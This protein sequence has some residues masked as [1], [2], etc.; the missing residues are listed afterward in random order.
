MKKFKHI[1]NGIIWTLIVLYL[2]LIVLMHLPSVQTFLGKEVAEALADKFGTKVE[3]GKVNLGFFNRIIIDDVM[4]YDQQGDSLIYASRLSAKIDYMAATQGKISVSS[5]Q[6]FGLRANLYR[7]TAKSPANFQFVL[8][9]LASK[10]TTQHKPLDLHI[11]SLIIRRGAIAYNQRDVAPRSGVFSPQHIRVSEL[12]SHILLNHVTDNSID[13][14]LKKLSF[15]DES[16]FKLQSLHFKLQADRQK[17]TLKEF[18]LL[19]PRSELVLDDLK[20]TYRFEGKRFIPES[21]RFKGGIQ[22]SKITFADVASLVPALRHF[23]DAVFVSSRFLGTAKSISVPSLN[24]RTGSGSINLQ[25]RGSYSH[26]SSHPAWNADIANLNLSPAGVEFLVENLGSKVKIPKEIQRLGTIHLTG[27]AKGYEKVLSAKGNIETD[28]GNIS[29]QAVKS[30]DRIKASVD[31]RGVNLG[32]ILDNRKLGTVVAKIDAHGT[33]KHIFA[34]GNIARFDYGN[35]DFH[36]IDIDGDYDMKT[37]RGTASIADPNVNLSVKGDYHLGSRLYALDAAINHL[38]PTVLGMKMHDPSYSLDNISISA[39]NK[40]K[41]GH[42]DIEAPFVSLYARGQYDLTTIYGSIMRL[43]ADKLPTI[44]GISKHAAKGY[45][46]FTLQANITSAEVLQRMFGLPLSLNLPVHING[47][48]SDAEKNVNL[49]INAPNFSWDGS[50]FHD[51]N[52]ELNTIGD[53]LRMEARISQGLPYEK[54]P[55]YR[56]RA[57]AAD[58]NLSTLLYYANQSSKLPIT[59]K[60]DART[61]FFTSDNG[62]TGVHVSVNPSEIM[63]GE[64]KWLLNPADII[65]RKNELTVDMLNFSHGDQHIIINGKATPQATDSIVADLKDV[66][67]AYILNLV[68]FHSVDFAGKASG[69][70]VVKSIFQTPEAYANLDVKDFVFEN[71]PLGTLH[72]KAAYDNQEGQ[73]NIDATAEDG[74]EHLTVIN[75]YVSPKRNYIDLGIEAHNTSLKFMENFC[76]SFLN[77]VEAWCKG[78]LNVV[79]DLKNINLVGDVVAHGRM[80]MKQLGTDYTFN[81]LRAHAIPDDIQF[82]GDSIYDSHYNGKHSHFALIRGGIHHKHLTRLSYD[83]DIDANNFLGFDTHEFGDDTFYGTVFATGTVGI[84]GKSGETIID[85]DATPEPHS[86]FVYNVASPDAISAGSFIHWNDATPYIYRPYSPDSDKDKKK[87]S[88]SDFS[89]DMRINFLVNTN[90]NLTLKLMMDDQTGDYITL[91]GNGVIRANYYNKGGLDMFGNY[92]VDHGQYKL[93]IQ[94]IIKKDF[95]FQPGGTIAFGGDPYNAPLNLQA[96]YTVNG[97]P[98][99]DLNI[100]RS[101]SSNNIRVDCL[102]DITGTPG[103]PKVD[104]SMDLPTVNSDAKQ[105]IYSVINSQEEMNQQV[106]Y[107]LGI[108]RF[109]TQTKNNQTSEDASQQS[110]T[111]LAMQSLLSGTISQQINNVLSSFVNSSNWNF[112]A[113]ISTGNEGFNNAEYEGILSGRLLNNRLLFN[114]QFGYRDNA[115]AT[116]SF[117]GDFDLRYLIFPNG[118]LSI[119]V[120]NQTNDRYFTRNSLNTQGVGLIMKKD[121]FNLRDL[122]GIKKKSKDK[123]KENKNKKKGKK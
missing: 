38:R 53:S 31:T 74:P 106:L 59:G 27:K 92:V 24:L 14:L 76:G 16:G 50:A 32:R 90:P 47:N 54:A 109:Y 49:Y 87:D 3:V 39:N 10:D 36:N 112:G 66:D 79:G 34:K 68:N 110:Q 104:F 67:V 23:D 64:K 98:L 61:Q 123:E 69:K 97:V 100:G 62:A 71:G 41:E 43:V 56:L 118:N 2:L 19:M 114:G 26:A 119:H 30:D 81:H 102:M 84:H 4:M 28:A 77:N 91:N 88:S 117:I 44:P 116:Q 11:G 99:S 46:D 45:N 22:Q 13:L 107:L 25:A 115:N 52:I 89:S 95:D 101:F 121:F 78:K 15:K 58:N 57:A 18:R 82:E 85:I 83:L 72:A 93:T 51:A 20:A 122:L 108:G 86:I 21:L 60:I 12:S 29:L 55:V 7:Q 63:L 75:G 48:I 6:I 111:S 40:G 113:N 8:D 17:A 96:K 94:N 120:Y 33:M 65:Y 80:H 35:Y 9:S 37:L 73:I 42:L 70:A 103:A 105:M 1:C 5:A